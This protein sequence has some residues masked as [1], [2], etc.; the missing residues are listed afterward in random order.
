MGRNLSGFSVAPARR[1]A[2]R[3]RAAFVFAGHPL[4][5]GTWRGVRLAALALSGILAAWPAARADPGITPDRIVV[6]Q[7]AAFQ[8]PAAA[9]GIGVREGLLAAFREVNVTGGL[10]GRTLQLVS[11]DDGYEPDE[12]I[13]NTRKLIEGDRV[14]A[15]IGEVGTPTSLAVQPIAT[16]AGVPF[17]GAFTGAGALRDARL[18]NVINVRAS[19][20]QE[21]EAWIHYVLD[22]LHLDRV[23][24]LYQDDSFGRAGL[25]G[26]IQALDKRGRKL[27]AEG[28]YMRN[29]TAVK[30][31]FLSIRKSRPDA[32]AMVGAYKPCAEF[33]R[34]ARRYGLES[35]FL[36]ISFVGSSALA[37]EL[38]ADGEGVIVSQV[39][40]LPDDRGIPVVARYRDALLASS[41]DAV[42]GFVSLEGYL[43]GR[44]FI[45]ALK[46]AGP[47]ITRERVLSAIYDTG[48][49]DLGGLKLTYGPGDNQGLDDVFLTKIGRDGSFHLVDGPTP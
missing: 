7:S 15:L 45:E 20:D 25:S 10:D 39:V 11:Y 2:W 32:V 9:L 6:G 26:V 42:P 27:V 8:G 17:I 37:K 36:N 24:I 38:G 30:T 4:K 3:L 40:P 29:T 23:A 19:Y 41:P 21:T 16:A 33:I 22:E 1:Q 43:T 35:L 14:F 13:K 48:T 34:L 31:A 12:A 28:T 47:E 49:F 46:K 5:G 44:L 18:R